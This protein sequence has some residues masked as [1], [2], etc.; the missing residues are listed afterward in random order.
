MTELANPEV[1]LE[2]HVFVA[3]V[4]SMHVTPI[5]N[6]DLAPI[7]V[8]TDG[9]IVPAAAPEAYVLKISI[10]SCVLADFNS[11]NVAVMA[12]VPVRVLVKLGAASDPAA[13]FQYTATYALAVPEL[14]IPLLS[15]QPAGVLG[16]V[17]EVVPAAVTHATRIFPA[18]RFWPVPQALLTGEVVDRVKV[19][20]PTW[21][22]GG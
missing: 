17:T 3:A 11:Y 18:V 8:D 5:A 1:P 9:A 14:P 13:S 12:A 4:R 7:V 22:I 20:V 19:G 6:T 2:V 21:V 16:A 10:G 15:V